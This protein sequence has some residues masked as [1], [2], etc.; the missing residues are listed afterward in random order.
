MYI[1]GI[2]RRDEEPAVGH[3]RRGEILYLRTPEGELIEYE[4]E[5]EVTRRNAEGQLITE[6]RRQNVRE[7]FDQLPEVVRYFTEWV[8]KSERMRWLNGRN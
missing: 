7:K 6:R 4:D 3:D 8:G 5:I 2:D 1:V